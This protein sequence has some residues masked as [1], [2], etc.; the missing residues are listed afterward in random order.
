MP[1]QKQIWGFFMNLGSRFWGNAILPQA[2][3]FHVYRDIT[4]IRVK[5]IT[6]SIE[7]RLSPVFP[8]TAVE[9]IL[10]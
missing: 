4:R 2:L 9:K 6:F 1:F 10:C 8:K 3:F 5:N 7:S